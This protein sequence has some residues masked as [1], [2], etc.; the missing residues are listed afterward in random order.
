MDLLTLKV[1]DNATQ[2]YVWKSK[3]ESEGIICFIFDENM[4]SINP[5]YTYLVGGIKL[6]IRGEDIIKAKKI[7]V[8]AG[9]ET[10]RLCPSCLSVQTY[11]IHIPKNFFYAL[12]WVF[13]P[14][15]PRWKCQDCGHVFL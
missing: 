1:F 6:K 10:V 15:K 12:F 8:E 14:P 3:L 7:L 5:H 13:S 4:I 11:E 9:D 2:A